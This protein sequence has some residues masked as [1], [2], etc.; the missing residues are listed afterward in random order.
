MPDS[1]GVGSV[2]VNLTIPVELDAVLAELALLTG[3]GKASFAAEAVTWYLPQLLELL[4][5]VK[6]RKAPAGASGDGGGVVQGREPEVVLA[7]MEG[8]LGVKFSRDERRRLVRE[9]R[10]RSVA[11]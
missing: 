6:G 9:M 4:E 11:K 10:A 1:R 5:A 8:A 2:R 3:R 7:S